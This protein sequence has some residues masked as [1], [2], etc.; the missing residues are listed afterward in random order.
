MTCKEFA[1]ATGYTVE[2]VR[3]MA[4]K[5]TLPA[6]LVIN[7]K[8]KWD[9]S[10]SLVDK[11]RAKKEKTSRLA[12]KTPVTSVTLYAREL[13]AYNKEHGTNYSYGE[14]V[15]KEVIRYECL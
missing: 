7:G 14:A 3:N 4:K 15:A 10:P 2:A 6:V 9:I 12:G 11:W 13:K 5:G 8:E 1:M